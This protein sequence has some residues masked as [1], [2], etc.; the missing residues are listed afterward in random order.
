[1][2]KKKKRAARPGSK[3]KKTAVKKTSPKKT[4]KKPVSRARKK[5]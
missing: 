1:M 5:K 2:G 3:T 4:A